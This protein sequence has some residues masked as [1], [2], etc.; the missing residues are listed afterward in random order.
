MT[1]LRITRFVPARRKPR[2]AWLRLAALCM[3]PVGLL[4]CGTPTPPDATPPNAAVGSYDPPWMANR[5]NLPPP[6]TDRINYDANSR[7][8]TL[9][10]LP[11]NDRW[12]VRFRGDRSGRPMTPR[13]TLPGDVDPADVFVYY[14]RPGVRPSTPVTVKQILD[15]GNAHS[16]LALR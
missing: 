7:T 13:H 15:N 2:G 1:A 4:G 14:S 8:L 5:S 11:G 6:D 9:Y 3:L 12:M 10:D 16:S